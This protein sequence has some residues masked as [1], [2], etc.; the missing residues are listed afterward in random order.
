MLLWSVHVVLSV[1][2]FCGLFMLFQ[3]WCAFVICSCCESGVR[4]WSVHV[5]LSVV[6]VCDLFML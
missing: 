4:L 3:V 1:V 6:C 2:C 5:V